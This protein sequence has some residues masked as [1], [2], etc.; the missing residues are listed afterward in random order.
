MK[1]KTADLTGPALDWAVA[2]CI[3]GQRY[4][5][6]D[7]VLVARRQRYSSEFVE[8]QQQCLHIS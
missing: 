1:I 8:R 4:G 3:F 6:N 2:K 7:L 5:D